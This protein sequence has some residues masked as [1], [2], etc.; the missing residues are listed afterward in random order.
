MRGLKYF[1]FSSKLKKEHGDD[2]DGPVSSKK[3]SEVVDV[4]VVEERPKKKAGKKP[5][6]AKAP[7]GKKKSR[8]KDK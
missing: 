4:E 7:P 2:L 8:K 3:S 1:E 5:R 6:M